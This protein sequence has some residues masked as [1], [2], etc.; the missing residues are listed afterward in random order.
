[1]SARVVCLSLFLSISPPPTRQNLLIFESFRLGPPKLGHSVSKRCPNPG[2]IHKCSLP[3]WASSSLCCPLRLPPVDDMASS[4]PSRLGLEVPQ[5]RSAPPEVT[6]PL[7]WSCVICWPS[8]R[9]AAVSQDKHEVG[10]SLRPFS[11]FFIF[12]GS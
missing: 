10:D 3:T 4:S 5:T 12:H 1:M 2:T 6:H 8:G 11:I 7:R 9:S